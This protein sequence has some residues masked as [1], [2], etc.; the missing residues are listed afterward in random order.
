MQRDFVCRETRKEVAMRMLFVV[1]A[2]VVAVT[3]PLLSTG[4]RAQQPIDEVTLT[5]GEDV[6]LRTL[7]P[8]VSQSLH[9]IQT[10]MQIFDRLVFLDT[11]GKF[12]PWLAESWESSK[13]GKSITFHLRRGVKFHDGS[14]FTAE[15][16]KFT[17]DTIRDPKLASQAAYDYLGPYQSTEVIDP[18][19]VRV[20]WKQPFAPAL[21][22]LSNPYLSIVSAT[23]VRKL[24]DDSFARDP[25]GSGPFK[26][27]EWIPRVRIVLE[28]NDEYRW[29]PSAFKHQGP[30]LIKRLV[31][32]IIPDASTRVNALERREIDVA[33]RL[34]PIDVKR[35]KA[36]RDFDVI[37]GDIAGFPVSYLFNTA[38]PPTD[39][40][41]VRQAFIQAV[42]RPTLVEQTF[43]GTR[44]PAYGPIAPTTI[45]YWPGVEKLYPYDP[46]KAR[47]LLDQAG[48]KVGSDGI[49]SKD[50]RSLDVSFPVLLE[51]E[52]AVGI[53]AAVKDVGIRLNLETVT[54]TKQDE[55][56]LSSAY[57]VLV[58]SWVSVDPSVLNI[59]FRCANIPSPGKFKFN[60][61]RFCSR[62]LDHM[63]DGADTATDA[64]QRKAVLINI[65]NYI[66]QHTL[67]FPI[68]V[69]AQTIGFHRSVR[70]LKFAP[71]F[72]YI[73]FYDATVSR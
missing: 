57:N 52:L 60:W 59:P 28:R 63:L 11:D 54:K 26:F 43:F 55:L 9:E 44:K 40:A 4:T 67:I 21:T 35:F 24:G 6:D 20:N 51:T 65:Q 13:D 73:F 66:M 33:A 68:H 32:R 19:T 61:A 34:P 15:A 29:A 2:L 3:L 49:R 7:D 72:W 18:Y 50:G 31:I 37:A 56:I 64:E 71:G 36:S 58:L 46:T 8:R 62:E 1:A 22:N 12:Y 14:S 42:D 27:V 30:A 45:G 10:F 23:A 41:R 25:V 70:N 48:W 5:W 38:S 16:V 47:Q 17:F 53:Q 69:E 39:D